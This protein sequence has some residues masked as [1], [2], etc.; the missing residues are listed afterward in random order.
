MLV[1]CDVT[2]L[3][4][5]PIDLTGAIQSVH[6]HT[7]LRRETKTI[8]ITYVPACSGPFLSFNIFG[9]TY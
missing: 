9:P 2:G 4:T 5:G 7:A 1:L 3:L 8:E 6:A